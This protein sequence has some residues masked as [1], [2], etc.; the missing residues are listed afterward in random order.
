LQA[1][2]IREEEV[3]QAE[4]ERQRL[5]A[6]EAKRQGKI[7]NVRGTLARGQQTVQS[8]AQQLPQAFQQSQQ[9]STPLYG[10]MEYFDPFGDPFAKKKMKMASSTNPADAT[11]IAAGGY[12]D[13]L[14][15]EDLS[16]D[17]L[18]NLLR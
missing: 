4:V 14:L 16:V 13:D 17:D 18:M 2:S 12:I 3:R 9:V 1:S 8:V 10:T 5:A 7:A 6:L 11:K 15:A